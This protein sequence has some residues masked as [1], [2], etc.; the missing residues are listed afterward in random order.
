MHGNDGAFPSIS[1][2]IIN[3]YNHTD[4]ADRTLATSYFFKKNYILR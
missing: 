3:S 1:A 2:L 4:L